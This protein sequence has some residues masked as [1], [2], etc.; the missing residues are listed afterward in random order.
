MMRAM[1]RTC[2]ATLAAVAFAWLIVAFGPIHATTTQAPV[3]PA[4]EWSRV[5]DPTALGFCQPG[6]DAATARAKTLATT[7][8]TVIVGG[9]VLWDYGDQQTIS[10]LASVRKSILAMLFGN[11]VEKGTIRLDK[12]M[13]DL[14]ITDVQG[15]LPREQQATRPPSAFHRF[16]WPDALR[17]A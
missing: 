17:S 15:L 16:W 4:A 3:F 13:K 5:T 14:N 2:R 8:A 9:R 6:L 7:A 11:Y 10:Y 1:S 12:T